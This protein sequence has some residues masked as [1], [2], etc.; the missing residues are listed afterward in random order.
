MKN[1]FFLLGVLFQY[2]WG[3]CFGLFIIIV[4]VLFSFNLALSTNAI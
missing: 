4:V 1:I 2:Y 3:Y